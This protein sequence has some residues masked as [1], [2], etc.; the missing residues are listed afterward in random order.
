MFANLTAENPAV[1]LAEGQRNRRGGSAVMWIVSKIELAKINEKILIYVDLNGIVESVNGGGSFIRKIIDH[2]N[3][4]SWV[5]NPVFPYPRALIEGQL[6]IIVH[7]AAGRGYN[8]Y[9]P[10]WRTVAALTVQFVFVANNG[11]I[12]LQ[13]VCIT[14]FI[15]CLEEHGKRSREY[16]A[17][18]I[19]VA[20]VVS[21]LQVQE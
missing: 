8:F 20:D 4:P 17:G 21:Y 12:W 15:L 13:V 16:L 9:N 7:L 10:I 6:F 2:N 11:Y 18:T 19:I 14:L 1:N 5:Y 3:F